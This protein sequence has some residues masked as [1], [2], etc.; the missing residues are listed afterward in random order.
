M[1]WILRCSLLSVGVLVGALASAKADIVTVTYEGNLVSGGDTSGIFISAASIQA[2]NVYLAGDAFELT[3]TFDTSK[4]VFERT[5]AGAQE[6][7]DSRS[8]GGPTFAAGLSSPG[9]ALLTINGRT[10]S[11]FVSSLSPTSAGFSQYVDHQSGTSIF[12]TQSVR[13]YVPGTKT[14]IDTMVDMSFTDNLSRIPVDLTTP[15]SLTFDANTPA[16][17]GFWLLSKGEFAYG[18]LVG[19]RVTVAVSAVPETSTWLMAI[20]GFLTI[21]LIVVVAD[22]GPYRHRYLK[23]AAGE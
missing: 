1:S 2:G 10:A 17:G 20:I 5:S 4:G 14:W 13:D 3:F 23:I 18:S 12:T 21:G 8:Q 7:T 19:T 6:V 16:T 11:F 22:R 9:T 15:Y